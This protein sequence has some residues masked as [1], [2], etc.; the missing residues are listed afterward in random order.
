[1]LNSSTLPTGFPETA[2]SRYHIMAAELENMVLYLERQLQSMRLENERSVEKSAPPD[3][4]LSKTLSE[5]LN[6]S[7]KP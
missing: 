1:M 5:N 4:E 7:F 3:T 2:M 6:N